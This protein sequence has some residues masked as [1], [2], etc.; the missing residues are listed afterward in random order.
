M[1]E[2]RELPE[3]VST[4]AIAE[5]I[6]CSQRR[7]QQLKKEGVLQSVKVGRVDRFPLAKTLAHYIAHLKEGQPTNEEQ[8]NEARKLAAEARYREIKAEQEAL[9]L[10]ELEG[11]MHR[12]EDVRAA[13][14]QLVHAVRSALL[15]LPG[16]LAVDV[17]SVS[18]ADEAS[19][20]IRRE[21]EAVLGDLTEYRYNPEAYAEMLKARTGMEV[22]AY[23]EEPGEGGSGP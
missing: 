21:V 9:K 2:T 20:I 19:T 11:A 5:C 10:A 7:V 1:A 22:T 4:K 6:G 18:S 23:A 3:L 16:R 8:G 12:S 13:T 14:G 17:S 15:S